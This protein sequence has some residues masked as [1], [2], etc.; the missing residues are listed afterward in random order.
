MNV[1]EFVSEREDFL[2]RQMKNQTLNPHRITPLTSARAAEEVPA[3]EVIVQEDDNDDESE[4]ATISDAVP[5][6]VVPT[7]KKVTITTPDSSSDHSPLIWAGVGVGILVFGVGVVAMM[8]S[9]SKNEDSVEVDE[10]LIED[11]FE[12]K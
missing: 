6:P 1:A 11:L 9:G 5:E 8:N 4:L 3:E 7:E 10:A 2:V 12:F